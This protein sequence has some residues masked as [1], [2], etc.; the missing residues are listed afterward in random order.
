MTMP[1]WEEASEGYSKPNWC[2]TGD[3]KHAN[4]PSLRLPNISK[5]SITDSASKKNWAI[6]RL[7]NFRSDTMQIYSLLKHM[8]SIFDSTPH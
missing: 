8:D 5:Y 6:Y 1:R 2:I 3:S 7:C 4:K